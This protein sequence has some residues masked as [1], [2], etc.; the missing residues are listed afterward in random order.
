MVEPK[1]NTRKKKTEEDDGVILN[2]ATCL[3][4]SG[5][6]LLDATEMAKFMNDTESMLSIAAGWMELAERF[7]PSP[8]SSGRKK[9]PLGFST[10]PMSKDEDDDDECDS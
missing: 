2:A 3:A 1:K 9:P 8:E 7:D 4:Q 10:F 6:T 5:Q